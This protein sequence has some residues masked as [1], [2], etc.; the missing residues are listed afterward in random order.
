MLSL[1]FFKAVQ[2]SVSGCSEKSLVNR[3]DCVCMVPKQHFFFPKEILKYLIDKRIFTRK[4]ATNTLSTQEPLIF[5]WTNNSFTKAYQTKNHLVSFCDHR[6]KHQL[7]KDFKF[8][9]PLLEILIY[10]R[11]NP[12][13]TVISSVATPMWPPLPSLLPQSRSQALALRCSHPMGPSCCWFTRLFLLGQG[14]TQRLPFSHISSLLCL[15]LQP[16]SRFSD[17]MWVPAAP[18][19][20]GLCFL[21]SMWRTRVFFL[22]LF[23]TITEHTS[24]RCNKNENKLLEKVKKKLKQEK[25]CINVNWILYY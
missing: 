6:S 14:E 20:I 1:S 7:F 12:L 16:A 19:I 4:C 10:T 23:E 9:H 11:H 3:T 8:K 2:V 15:L 5:F 13:R 22:L 25:V 17:K 21:N 24:V 18:H